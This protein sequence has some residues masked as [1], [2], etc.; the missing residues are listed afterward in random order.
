L[1]EGGLGVAGGVGWTQRKQE[2]QDKKKAH[3]GS[4]MLGRLLRLS[5]GS[6]MGRS[7]LGYTHVRVS[8]FCN[9]LSGA[10]FLGSHFSVFVAL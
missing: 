2:D 7:R 4:P 10:A 3:V 9:R 5:Y 6:C 8:R 1:L